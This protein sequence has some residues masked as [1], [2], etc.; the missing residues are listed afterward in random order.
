MNLKTL[1]IQNEPRQEHQDE[2]DIKA[3]NSIKKLKLANG[4][5]LN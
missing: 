2:D 4:L 1:W 5:Y 3:L